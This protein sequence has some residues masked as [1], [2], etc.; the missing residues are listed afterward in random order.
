ML[1]I[2]SY[3]RLNVSHGVV[4]IELGPDASSIV[5]AYLQGCGRLRRVHFRDFRGGRHFGRARHR[6]F[7]YRRRSDDKIDEMK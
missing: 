7:R 1:R 4:H 5:Q 6:T 3:D 2:P